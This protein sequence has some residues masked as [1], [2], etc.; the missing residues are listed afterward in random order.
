MEGK[1]TQFSLISWLNI[2][3]IYQYG[4]LPAQAV[5]NGDPLQAYA[6]QPYAGIGQYT[7]LISCKLFFFSALSRIVSSF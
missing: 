1:K 3:N 4:L 6:V 5:A 7:Q 2:S